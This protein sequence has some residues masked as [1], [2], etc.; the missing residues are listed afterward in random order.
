VIITGSWMPGEFPRDQWSNLSNK[1]GFLPLF[2]LA[3][4]AIHN[5]T[6]MGGCEFSMGIDNFNG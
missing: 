5:S 6:M 4:D 3:S 2:P 1:V